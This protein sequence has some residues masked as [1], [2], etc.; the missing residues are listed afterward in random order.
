MSQADDGRSGW[1]PLPYSAPL[2]GIRA[3]AI[4]AV[5]I[6]H[7]A[8]ATLRGGFVGVDV[9]FVL[10]G[11]L[12]TSIILHDLRAGVFSL[13][14]FYLR[15]IQRLL[16]NTL[17]TILTVVV[18]WTLIMP[19]SAA[20]QAGRHGVWTVFNLSNF[21]IWK[22][23]G[24]YWA[25]AAE[26][27][28][29][30]HTWS[31]GIEEQFYLL[32][33]GCLWIIAK[34]WPRRVSS[35]LAFAA[36]CSFG[37][38]LYGTRIHP[39]ATFYL[40]PTRVWELL[41]G[42]ILA[43]FH[44][45]LVQDEVA[46]SSA[47]STKA[48][49]FLGA[50]GAGL[51]IA[52]C[53][54]IDGH[55]GFPGLVVLAPTGGAALV[56]WSIADGRTR[57]SRLL[58]NPGMV[59]TGKLSYSIYLW[60]WP[61]ISLGKALASLYAVPEI[62]GTLAGGS[63][64][65]LLAVGAYYTVEQPL[66]RRGPGRQW[67]FA[68][69]AAGFSVVALSAFVVS[70]RRVLADPGKLFDTPTF[71]GKLYAAGRWEDAKDAN[72]GTRFYDV[73]FPPIPRDRSNDLWRKGGVVH[74]YG[75]GNPQVVVL[76]SS[77]AMMYSHLIDNIC[78][79][80]NISVAFLG[81]DWRTPVF[82]NSTLN[83]NFVSQEEAKEFDSA[84]KKWIQDWHPSVLFMMDRW[85]IRSED[86]ATFEEDLGGFLANVGNLADNIYFVAQIPAVREGR[87]SVNLREYVTW[88]MKGSGR[89]PSLT[90][91]SLEPL[92][93][94]AVAIAQAKRVLF[95]NFYILRADVPFYEGD[96]SI[97]FASGRTFFYADANHLTDAG[98]EQVR[99][100]FQAAIMA[101]RTKGHPDS[102][103]NIR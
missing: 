88:R 22:H 103:G 95:P 45:P 66:R 43:A 67:R 89:M 6:F 65:L 46:V 68:I 93:K 63:A 98:A 25:D 101:A 64:A 12:I 90:P 74:L 55:S 5:F 13:R 75:G 70:N 35:V 50:I 97:R 21:Y 2:D 15:R 51:I 7:L 84:R 79:D 27:S 23:L 19:P 91:D 24:G 40:L 69:I 29:L 62:Y 9:F 80:F 54:L 39:Q 31:L 30:T 86:P 4:L 83:W 82:F 48:L 61:L 76:G 20:A 92:R 41:I 42:A 59:W 28:P 71:F 17:L 56:L 14:E 37:A 18:L 96:G 52:G 60:H 11:F 16:P 100:L 85:D 53:F 36:V 99:S 38:C 57:L 44:T 102:T 34:R 3:I 49:E 1:G 8:P 47:A 33:P 26:W 32:F 10:S 77:H 94:Q 72:P 78:H 87:N 81:M 58:S 73:T